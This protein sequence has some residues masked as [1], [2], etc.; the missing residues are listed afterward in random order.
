MPVGLA[1]ETPERNLA[2]IGDLFLDARDFGL[3]V[4]R[5]RIM[6]AVAPK[7]RPLAG[8][9]RDFHV[10]G[11]ASVDGGLEIDY[12]V[13]LDAVTA[14]WARP[15]AI[16]LVLLSG[17]LI[18]VRASGH[19]LGIEAVPQRR[20]QHRRGE[21]E[22]PADG[23][24][25]G[26]A[27]APRIRRRGGTP[28]VS[29]DY[30][31]PYGGEVR[32]LARDAIG[33]PVAAHIDGAVAQARNELAFFTA[34]G[35]KAALIDQIGRIDGAARASPM[36]T[37][38]SKDWSCAAPSRSRIAT[39]PRCRSRRR[40]PAT[41][42]TRSG[43]GSRASASTRSVYLA[44]VHERCRCAAR[45]AGPRHFGG[46]LPA[47]PAA[48]TEEQLRCG[49]APRAA[50]TGARRQW[51]GVPVIRDMRVDHVTGALVPITSVRECA[52]YGYEF[53]MPYEVGAYG[54]RTGAGDQ[55]GAHRRARGA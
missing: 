27:P 19:G 44:L 54:R 13:R 29:L 50:A 15:F 28:V 9:Q 32:P 42:S 41:A 22:R 47:A 10:H 23:F 51:A 6:A 52:Q 5:D 11:D 46:Y 45:T 24:Q 34:P 3:A 38:V 40:R 16:S 43:A 2:S 26:A 48:G 53:R 12:H 1:G 31:G 49:A 21:R 25:R 4:S 35:R 33:G 8:L 36:P 37:F 17:G 39:S 30:H 55:R 14:Q 20:L 18:R 7:L